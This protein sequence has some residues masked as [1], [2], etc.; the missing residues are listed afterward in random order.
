[1]P[2]HANRCRSAWLISLN[3]CSSDMVPPR[4]STISYL[5]PLVKVAVVG[6]VVADD[7]LTAIHDDVGF[8]HSFAVDFGDF[9]QPDLAGQRLAVNERRLGVD[10]HGEGTPESL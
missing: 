3:H 8:Q 4:A 9:F 1:M 7:G 2:F 10:S 5:P 6:L